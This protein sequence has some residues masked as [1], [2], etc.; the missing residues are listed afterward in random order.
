VSRTTLGFTHLPIQWVANVLSLGLKRP[1]HK[2]D[3]APLS[4]NE[5]KN[6]WSYTSIPQYVFMEWCLV[7][8]RDN[9]KI[10][11]FLLACNEMY[12]AV[13]FNNF[14]LFNNI[15]KEFNLYNIQLHFIILIQKMIITDNKTKYV[16]R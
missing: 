4:S 13:R 11:S 9:L 5:V 12:P 1:G 14:R 16:K 7:K 10:S 8:H 3:H 15:G 2:T 6:A